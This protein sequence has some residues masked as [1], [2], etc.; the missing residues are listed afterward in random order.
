MLFILAT[1]DNINFNLVTHDKKKY[2]NEQKRFILVTH[3]NIK[4]FPF[5]TQIHI[6]LKKI[7]KNKNKK[8]QRKK[9][10]RT[11]IEWD[12][13]ILPPSSI[14]GLPT[15]NNVQGSR[16]D[17]LTNGAISFSLHVT[18]FIKQ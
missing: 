12:Y 13:G 15:D 8:K 11:A 6:Q 5:V 18:D 4:F 7:N 9:K 17:H 16:R 1:H 3:D 2:F 14:K 10:L